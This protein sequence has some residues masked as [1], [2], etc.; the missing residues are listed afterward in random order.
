MSATTESTALL[1]T[2]SDD[3]TKVLIQEEFVD[4]E[5]GKM[6][7]I[8]F[9]VNLMKGIAGT[10]SLALPFAFNQVG[11]IAC[12]LLFVLVCGMM[13]LATY[14]LIDINNEVNS[15]PPDAF[16]EIKTNN[17]YAELV[18]KVTGNIGYWIYYVCS[19]ITLYG[20]NIGSMVVMTDFLSALPLGAPQYRRLIAQ[21]ILTVLCIILCLL[22]DP[23][24]LVAVSSLGLFAI[25]GGFLALI[26]FGGVKFG[27]HFAVSDLWPKSF[28]AFLE[29]FGIIVY[30]MGFILFL[31]TQYKYLRRDCQK[32]V[33]RSTGI[34]ISLMAIIYSIIGILLAVIFKNGPH[35]V[36]DDI[37]KSLPDGAW[38]AIP[39]NLLM[40]ITVIGGFPLW[41]EP[42][43]EMVEGHWGE[44]TKGKI[45][46]TNPVYIIFRIVE[47]VLISVVAYFVPHFGDILSVVGNFTDNIT[48]FIFPA[49]MHLRLLRK[50]RS[51]G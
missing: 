8:E 17:T 4:D 2:P 30:C 42:V 11:I 19:L 3:Q 22:K 12:I 43:N 23:K 33:V 41:M 21:L 27:I 13:I 50:K 48:T 18:F 28:E 47:I 38:I 1:S 39:V 31:L 7:T 24:M 32:T 36:E 5:K 10:G 15:M 49:F 25:A 29:N 45:F 16:P 26:I 6:N 35:G 20:S 51:I 44:C 37:V 40:V 14:Q 9:C 46:I 34:S